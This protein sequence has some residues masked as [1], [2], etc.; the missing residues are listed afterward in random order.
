[1]RCQGLMCGN[2]EL[3]QSVKNVRV[4]AKMNVSGNLLPCICQWYYRVHAYLKF[5]LFSQFVL[6][7]FTQ[8]VPELSKQVDIL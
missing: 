6:S 8:V 3:A 1:M 4:A 2:L 5:V 7:I